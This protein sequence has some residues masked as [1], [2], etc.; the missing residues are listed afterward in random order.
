[1]G[2]GA[3]GGTIP[4]QPY[5]GRRIQLSGDLATY[6]VQ[7]SASAWLRV[8]GANGKTASFDGMADRRLRGTTQWRPFS[9]VVNV[10]RDALDVAFGLLTLGRGWIWATDMRVNIVP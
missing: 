9:I 1:M 5:R 10:P 4:V 7:G 8:D 3:I 2:R 6:D